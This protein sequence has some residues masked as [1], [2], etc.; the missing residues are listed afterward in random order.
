MKVA[1]IFLYST[2]ITTVWWILLQSQSL[3]AW[4]FF[5]PAVGIGFALFPLVDRSARRLS[6]SAALSQVMEQGRQLWSG[7]GDS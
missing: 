4:L 3:A 2:A 6:I 1:I 5:L 7:R